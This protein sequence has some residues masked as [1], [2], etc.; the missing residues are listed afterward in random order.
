MIAG[1][2]GPLFAGVSIG[3]ALALAGV[4]LSMRGDR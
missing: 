1:C 2:W 4:G 3:A